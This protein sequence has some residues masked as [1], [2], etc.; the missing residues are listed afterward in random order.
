MPPTDSALQYYL[1]PKADRRQCVVR[2]DAA[3]P[4]SRLSRRRDD[5]SP[6]RDS[7][8]RIGLSTLAGSAAR[9][10]SGVGNTI[11]NFFAIE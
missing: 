3:H 11:A 10:V 5:L 8:Q 2:P 4:A 7:R 9:W 6:A 1:R